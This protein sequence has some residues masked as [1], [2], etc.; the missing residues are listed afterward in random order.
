M[1]ASQNVRYLYSKDKILAVVR[2][3]PKVTS[4]FAVTI[5]KPWP[6]STELGR[7]ARNYGFLVEAEPNHVSG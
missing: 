6:S 2:I 4:K 7:E 1:V 3:W 5:P